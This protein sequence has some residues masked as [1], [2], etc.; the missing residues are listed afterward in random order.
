MAKLVRI[1]DLAEQIRG[2]TFSKGEAQPV[3]A[4]GLVPVLTASNVTEHGLVLDSVLHVPSAKISTRQYLRRNDVVITASSGSLSVVGRAAMVTSD[5]LTAGFGAFCKVLRPST[6]IDPNYFAQ[7]FKTPQYRTR[8]SLLAAGANI[9][10]LRN[11]DLDNLEIPLPPLP[12]QRRIASI[13]DQADELRANRRSAL[14]LLDDLADSIFTDMFGDVVA[15]DRDWA[16]SPVSG[17][18]GGFESGKSVVG[19]AGDIDPGR[20]RVLK[21]SSVTSGTFDPSESKALPAEY[22]PPSS[23]FVAQGDLLF[24]RANTSEL[25]GATA[26]VLDPVRNLTL[27]D[28]LWRF[29]WSSPA[30]VDPSFVWKM[31]SRPEFRR[32]ISEYSTGSSGSMKN[33]SQAAILGLPSILPPLQL[34]R[35]FSDLIGR[36][37]RARAFEFTHL[38]H[39]DELFASLQHRA[40]RGEL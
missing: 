10:N 31:F 30:L 2:V 7:Y 8:V 9:N 16:M 35:D 20:P 11:E 17:F 15:N 3:A 33:V 12:E 26:L 34:Q 21:I 18:V 39:L 23:H 4:D 29:V 24:S 28:K 6:Q 32:L 22:S 37:E 27:P 1:G 36:I 14:T 5:D 25:V 13:L 40:F 38:A 19:A